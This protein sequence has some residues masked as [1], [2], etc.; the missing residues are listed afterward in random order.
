VQVVGLYEVAAALLLSVWTVSAHHLWRVVPGGG[1]FALAGLAAVAWLSCHL[2]VDAWAFRR[3]QADAVVQEAALLARD[4]VVA[5]AGTPIELVDAG[6][7]AETGQDGVR[8][9]LLVQAKSGLEIQR[10][11]GVTRVWPLPR[12]AWALARALQAAFVAW[13]IARSLHH[14][15][16]EPRCGLCG[17]YLRRQALGRVAEAHVDLLRAAWLAGQRETPIPVANGG[18]WALRDT[19]PR[20]HTT[21]PGFTLV[22]PRQRRWS[23]RAPGPLAQLKAE[24]AAPPM[25]SAAPPPST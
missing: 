4:F 18:I 3:E 10:A 6:L 21:L 5:G 15:G 17:S 7:R 24:P 11:L 19:C 25:A 1:R 20:G 2:W 8:G 23:M 14:L 16:T 13:V 9:A 22:R 12:W